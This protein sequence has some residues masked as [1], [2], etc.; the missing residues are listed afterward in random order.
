MTRLHLHLACLTVAISGGACAQ[1]EHSGPPVPE[2][3]ASTVWYQIF[4]ERFRNGDP[5][6]DPVARSLPAEV[7]ESW[8]VSE[9]TGDWYARSDWERQ[10]SGDFYRTVRLRRYGGDLQG[11]MDQLDYLALLGVNGLYFNPLFWARSEH[12]YDGNT[13]HHIDPYFGPDPQ[14]DFALMS[15]ETADPATWHITAADSLFFAMLDAAHARGIRVIIDGVFNHTGRD[16][17]AFDDLFRNQKASPYRDWYKVT[18]W[19]DPATEENEF[20]WEG[21]WGS[22][23]LPEFADSRDGTDLHPGPKS[24][25]FQATSRWMDP[26]GDGDPSDGVDGWRLD[27]VADVPT[28]FW[29]DWNAHV[30]SL[31]PEAYTVAELWEDAS[32]TVSDGGFS[33]TMNYFGFAFPVKGFLID[34]A[35]AP[36][37]FVSALNARR[38]AHPPDVAFAVQNLIDSHDTDRVASMIVNAR[39]GLPYQRDDWQTW[40]DYDWGARNSPNGDP[41][42]PIA[43]PTGVDREIQR[44]VGL[45]QM[46]YVGAPMIYYGTEAGMWSADDPDDRQ[47][48]WWGDRVFEPVRHHPLGGPLDPIPV[49]FDPEL[50]GYYRNVIALRRS[51]P[52]LSRGTFRA[53]HHDDEAQTVAFV[54]ELEEELL[55]VAFNRG[56]RK[57]S[58]TLQTENLRLGVGEGLYQIFST[59]GDPSLGEN[60]GTLSLDL[61]A[62]SGAVFIRT[63]VE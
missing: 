11:V 55:L 43:A 21:W 30:R 19:D 22:R 3:A 47:P 20:D 6:N 38:Q 8:S 54:R 15:G 23:Y 48:M 51:H 27:V 40:F 56:A 46:T 29:A 39:R 37:D 45:F 62:H 17:F 16:F 10:L 50:F 41:D 33:A 61:P 12:K 31:N 25:I 18:R 42:Y 58:I 28:G 52:A 24:Y 34:G 9:W 63:G 36:S 5:T 60:A 32:R 1:P 7:P 4:P 14:G 49:G 35:L 26:N 59:E 57:A 2:W 44:M 13:Y 53:V